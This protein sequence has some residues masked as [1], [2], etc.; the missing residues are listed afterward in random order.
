MSQL[1]A[2]QTTIENIILNPRYADL[3]AIVKGAR[4]GLVYGARVRFPHALVYVL[5]PSNS[6]LTPSNIPTNASITV[7]YS[8]SAPEAYRKK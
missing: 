3:F 2:L 4:N 5:C 7:W 8:S 6:S 1:Q